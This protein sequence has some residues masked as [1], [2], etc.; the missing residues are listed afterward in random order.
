MLCYVEF[1]Y[2]GSLQFPNDSKIASLEVDQNRPIETA[3]I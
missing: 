3:I 1:I 2:V